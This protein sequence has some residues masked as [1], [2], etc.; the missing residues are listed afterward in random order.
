MGQSSIKKNL[1]YKSIL[2]IANP[3][4]GILTFPYIS[5]VLGVEN[6]GLVNFVDNTISYFLL[7]ASMGVSTIGVRAIASSKNNQATLNR[8]F[9]NI[10][11]LN[12]IFTFVVLILFNLALILIPRF[13]ANLE[14]FLIGNA[15]ILFTS[16]LIEWFYSGIENFKFVYWVS[17]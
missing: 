16:L 8:V 3:I 13:N 17:Q 7:F 10:L 15:K 2:T 14:L 6:V 4:L 5:R 1:I 12:L 11:G 9:S